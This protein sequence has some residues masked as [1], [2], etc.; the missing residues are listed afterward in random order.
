MTATL[1]ETPVAEEYVDESHPAIRRL[2]AFVDDLDARGCSDAHIHPGRPVKRLF[3]TGLKTAEPG[4]RFEIFTIEEI[5]NW[6]AFGLSMRVDSLSEQGKDPYAVLRER[7]QAW[8]AFD[9]GTR[10]VRSTFRRSMQGLTVTFRVIA[11]DV[12]TADKLEVP[13]MVQKLATRSSGLVLLTG[14]T[15]SGKSSTIA[16]LIRKANHEK[17]P[18]IYTLEDPIEFVHEEYGE[19]SIIQREIG[20]HVADYPTGIEDALRSKPNII[21][22]GELLNP[23]TTRAALHAATTGHLVF[24]TAHAGSAVEALQSFIGQFTADEQPQIRSRL[25]DSLLA[26]VVQTLVP[27]VDKKLVAA[28]EV[29]IIDRNI[30]EL[31]RNENTQMLRAQLAGGTTE[32]FTLES[33]LLELVKERRI[34]PEVAIAN[35]KEPQELTDELRK[36][37]L[38]P[39]GDRIRVTGPL[40]NARPAPVEGRKPASATPA[41]KPTKNRWFGA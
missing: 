32:G 40:S 27:T 36:A 14:P 30:A 21:L 25:A 4:D 13:E 20:T 18:H 33:S 8:I 35:A 6:L 9:T 39:S 41:K 5:T 2:F 38:A 22:V 19:T 1:T 12:P 17:S 26:V 37:G 3:S 28:R 11:G 31:I 15:G 23:A 34:T 29:G 7:G 24:T 10:R 16:S